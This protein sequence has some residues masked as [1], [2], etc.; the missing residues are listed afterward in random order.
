[1]AMLVHTA[2]SVS[3]TQETR[4]GVCAKL[5]YNQILSKHRQNVEPE[6]TPTLV[7]EG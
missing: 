7:L 6:A 1:M 4:M 3:E 5:D 2:I